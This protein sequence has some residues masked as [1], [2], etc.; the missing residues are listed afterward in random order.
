MIFCCA[1]LH[2][3]T[4]SP[5]LYINHAIILVELDFYDHFRVRKDADIN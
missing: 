5:N 1:E 2:T 3:F 4:L